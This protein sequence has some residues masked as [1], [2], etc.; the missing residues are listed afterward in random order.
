MKF[1][2]LLPLLAAC[3]VPRPAAEP[4][5]VEWIYVQ[6]SPLHAVVRVV[7]PE[8]AA[9]HTRLLRE[10]AAVGDVAE[11]ELW[12][13]RPATVRLSPSRPGIRLLGPETV[14]VGP[15]PVRVSFTADSPGRGTLRAETQK[16]R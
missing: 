9:I 8:P 4:D 16:E 7:D 11:M 14:R 1:A 2:L 12:A 10:T 3:A 6:S 13:D 15:Q 5:E